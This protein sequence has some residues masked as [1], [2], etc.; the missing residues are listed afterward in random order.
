MRPERRNNM[1]KENYKKPEKDD[2]LF[3]MD[4][5]NAVSVY[6]FTGALPTPP[7]N[8]SEKESYLDILNYSPETIDIFGQKKEK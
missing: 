5:S 6:E 3:D 4:I 2:F 7:K 8:N 1:F